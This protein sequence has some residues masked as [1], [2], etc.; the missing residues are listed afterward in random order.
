MSALVALA[1]AAVAAACG[2]EPARAP[3]PERPQVFLAGDGELWVV[4]VAGERA[5]RLALRELVPGDPPVRISR[6]GDGMALWGHDVWRLD[7]RRPHRRLRRLVRDGLFFIPS[8]HPS[9]L[10][11]AL[12][13]R[14]SPDTVKRLRAVREVGI[15]GSVT[16]ADVRPPHGAWPQVAVRDG[17]LFQD[18]REGTY[19]WDPVHRQ[20]IRRW[21]AGELGQAGAAHRDLIASCTHRCTAIRLTDAGTGAQRIATAPAG[22]TLRVAD[23]AFSPGGSTLAVPVE[24]GNATRGATARLALVD[25]SEARMR[26]IAGSRVASGYTFA[27]WSR[28]GGYAFL[29]GERDSGDRVLVAYRIGE[30]RARRLHVELGPFYDAAAY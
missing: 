18:D 30:P 10:W 3:S 21:D 22:W 29:T 1:L 23:A 5:E 16:I 27:R 9:R 4:D 12:L 19:L 13:D 11:V 26:L 17:L 7:P 14:R 8:A 6:R 2:S 28:G 20:V 25:V 15:D 24:R